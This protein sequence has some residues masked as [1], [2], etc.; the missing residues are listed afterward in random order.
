ML[1]LIKKSCTVPW[2]LK[3]RGFLLERTKFAVYLKNLV[4]LYSAIFL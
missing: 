3:I 1:F 2:T 4:N